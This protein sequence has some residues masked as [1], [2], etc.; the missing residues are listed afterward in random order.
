MEGYLVE[1]LDCRNLKTEDIRKAAESLRGDFLQTPPA[2]SAKKIKGKPAYYYARRN[3]F[4]PKIQDM[5]SSVVKIFDIE[6][7][8]SDGD[9]YEMMIHC[10]SG[11]YIRSVIFEIGRKL[12]C[13]ATMSGLVR[14]A[15]GKFELKHCINA[16]DVDIV[17]KS[18]GIAEYEKSI[19]PVERLDGYM[20]INEN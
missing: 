4:D 9:E 19:I 2:F 20:D 6:V 13:G 14:T 11:T 17:A 10:S 5:K 16:D 18:N 15:I 1:S 12:G 7:I 3:P 8:S